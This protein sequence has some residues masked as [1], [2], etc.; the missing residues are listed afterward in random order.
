M[1]CGERERRV[2][3]RSVGVDEGSGSA[4]STARAVLGGETPRACGMT[5]WKPD[6]AYPKP[7]SPAGRAGG[8]GGRRREH[9]LAP[10]RPGWG[11]PLLTG[12]KG[13][14]VLAG[15]RRDLAEEAEDDAAGLLVA[16]LCAAA[17]GGKG[18][19][20]YDSAVKGTTLEL[21]GGSDARGS[22]WSWPHD[23]E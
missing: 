16:D 15:L 7:T 17:A 14:E 3:S 20:Y 6:P 18:M 8:I 21:A 1:N 10:V 23:A 9:G 5:R 4:R 22:D 12:A 13:A 11:G 2:H 19:R